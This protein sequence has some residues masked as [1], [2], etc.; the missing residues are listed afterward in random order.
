TGT[1]SSLPPTYSTDLNSPYYAMVKEVYD[2]SLTL[3][4]EQIATAVYYRDNPGYPQATNYLSTFSQV[5]HVE[6]PQLD[7][8]ALAHA[9]LGIAFAEAMINCW[10]I[11]YSVLQERPTRYIR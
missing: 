3:T 9:K 4:P 6:N 5:M 10:K 1:A 2:V 11:K 7:F 8:Y